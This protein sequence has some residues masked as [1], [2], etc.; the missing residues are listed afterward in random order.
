MIEILFV[1]KYVKYGKKSNNLDNFFKYF[2]SEHHFSDPDETVMLQLFVSLCIV[3]LP[4]I[5]MNGLFEQ[6]VMIF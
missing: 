2:L 1:L 3:K 4:L 6:N 5:K